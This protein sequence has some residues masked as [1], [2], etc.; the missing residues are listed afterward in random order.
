[1]LPLVAR[2]AV[3]NTAYHF[4]KLYDYLVPPGLD[5][6][7]GQRVV[8]PFGRGKAPQRMGLVL[9]VASIPPEELPGYTLRGNFWNSGNR[10]DG[11]WKVTFPLEN[12]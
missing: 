2:V 4:D 11:N 6:A 7:P 9:E 8:I 1:M 10:V 3:E 5:L 12:R